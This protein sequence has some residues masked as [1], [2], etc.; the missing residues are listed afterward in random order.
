MIA[1]RD[2][3]QVGYVQYRQRGGF[4]DN[5]PSGKLEIIE[6]VGV[7]TRATASLWKYA[8]STDL[9]PTVT[10]WNAPVDD[11]LIHLASDVRRIA[12][13]RNDTLW[14]RIEDVGAVLAARGFDDR[15]TLRVGDRTFGRCPEVA[16]APHAL[17][18][19]VMGAS[20]ASEL[21]QAGLLGGD[22]MAA[23]RAFVTPVALEQVLAGAHP[24]VAIAGDAHAAGGKKRRRIAR[25]RHRRAE[26]A[27]GDAHE[28]RLVGGE[29]HDALG[30]RCRPLPRDERR[31][32]EA[33]RPRGRRRT[34]VR[35]RHH[36]RRRVVEQP[37]RVAG[38]Q[39]RRGDVAREGV[40]APR[41][42]QGRV[43]L[44]GRA[45]RDERDR[46]GAAAGVAVAA[47]AVGRG[48]IADRCIRG[49]RVV[50]TAG[51]AVRMAARGER[52]HEQAAVHGVTSTR[53]P[54]GVMMLASPRSSIDASPVQLSE[55]ANRSAG[56]T[57]LKPENGG[58]RRSW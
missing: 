11:P 39:P 51:G 20:R 16:V 55:N 30:A 46:A 34:A 12:R 37:C 41:D 58:H 29:E 17:P 5:R 13:R 31:A 19:L 14:L 57:M 22:V 47:G 24:E 10:W 53:S 43:D 18:A 1:L 6:L 44:D 21:A 27:A 4:T 45:A 49:Q 23:E 25:D 28:H 2:G 35:G 40:E 7:D 42:G 8:C 26:H 15:V 56:H 33:A 54:S 52:E 3:A 9:Y 36:L 38:Q 48:G 50:V 32:S